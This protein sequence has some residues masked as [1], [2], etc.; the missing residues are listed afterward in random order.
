MLVEGHL[1]GAILDV[2]EEEPV[3]AGSPLLG[4]QSSDHT[5]CIGQLPYEAD[6]LYSCK[7]RGR[8]S[9]GIP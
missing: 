5:T 9:G 4:L 6:S 7:D 8:E 3:P 1:G 2:T